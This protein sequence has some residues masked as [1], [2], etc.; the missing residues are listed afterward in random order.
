MSNNNNMD[1]TS[2]G[3]SNAAV[4]MA[5]SAIDN[6]R[7]AAATSR[8]RREEEYTA[9]PTEMYRSQFDRPSTP[10]LH[11]VPGTA[12]YV[13]NDYAHL[14]F[15]GGD[16]DKSSGS[17]STELD[18]KHND[19]AYHVVATLVTDRLLPKLAANS[20]YYTVSQADVEFFGQML[21]PSV[22]RA[23]VEALRYRLENHNSSLGE[24][25]PLEKITMQCQM[26]GLNRERNVLLDLGKGS[27]MTVSISL[28]M[29]DAINALCVIQHELMRLT[30][31]THPCSM[32][33]NQNNHSTQFTI[34]VTWTSCK[35]RRPISTAQLPYPTE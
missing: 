6:A 24:F 12:E 34:V 28:S 3:Q 8:S 7:R 26:L 2:L 1:D 17:V 22:R 29:K 32:I 9:T 19:N 18:L 35:L 21:P 27:G 33:N 14:R 10:K 15:K 25:T 23:F 16:G 30:H 31:P 13:K 5:N 20:S 11:P 4:A